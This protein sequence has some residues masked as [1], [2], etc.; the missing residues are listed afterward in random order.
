MQS[1]GLQPLRWPARTRSGDFC[2]AI[3]KPILWVLAPLGRAKPDWKQESESFCVSGGARSSLA[4]GYYLIVLT[5][6]QFSSLRSRIRRTNKRTDERHFPAL[7]F[8]IH[9]L[10]TLRRLRL[11][12]PRGHY[13]V[14]VRCSA[15]FG[16][17]VLKAS[18][19]SRS[20]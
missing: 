20:Q 8:Q 12:F 13:R 1:Q 2:S 15:R 11:R 17:T 14:A 9:V 18:V 6:L 16:G 3:L 10:G 5:G 19:L 4:L 7:E